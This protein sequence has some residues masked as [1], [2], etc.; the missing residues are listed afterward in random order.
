METNDNENARVQ[1]FWDAANVV[2]RGKHLPMQAYPKKQ[3][4]FQINK[5]TLHLKELEEE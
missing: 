3:E 1:N 4:I 5:L 2:L